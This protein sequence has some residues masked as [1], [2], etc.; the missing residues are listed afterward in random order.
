MNIY[1]LI[2]SDS[3]IDET[4]I[5]GVF[6]TA[7]LAMRHRTIMDKCVEWDWYIEGWHLNDGNRIVILRYD[8]TSNIWIQKKNSEI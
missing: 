7:A 4:H 2:K 3:E 1:I 6:N 5:E 8:S